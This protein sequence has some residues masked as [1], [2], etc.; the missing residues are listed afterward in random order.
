M[1]LFA[2]VYVKGYYKRDGTYVRPHMRSNP[3]RSFYNN[4]STK[5]NVNPYTGKVG[6]KVYPTTV[7]SPTYN[8]N[9]SVPNV[10]IQE[11]KPV[12]PTNVNTQ[13]SSTYNTSVSSTQRQSSVLP[14]YTITKSYPM[15]LEVFGKTWHYLNEDN[16]NAVFIAKHSEYYMNYPVVPVMYLG[17]KMPNNSL[18]WLGKRFLKLAV[19]CQSNQ[20]TIIADAVVNSAG[21]T[22]KNDV[23]PENYPFV[24][25]DIANHFSLDDFNKISGACLPTIENIRG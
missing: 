13:I 8:H 10:N 5:G 14:A 24:W 21:N 23:Y 7:Y 1:S 12:Y 15:Q 25:F 9:Y 6:T 16:A 17:V 19:N 3:D 22:V 2:D 4:W 11:R 20:V 18:S